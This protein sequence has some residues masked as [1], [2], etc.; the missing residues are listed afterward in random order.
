LAQ[1][2]AVRLT[3]ILQKQKRLQPHRAI[4]AEADP[5]QLAVV[6]VA[7]L[8]AQAVTQVA[9]LVVLAVTGQK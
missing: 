6:V 9:Q 4:L 2:T 1:V 8:A 7:V 5:L 3:A